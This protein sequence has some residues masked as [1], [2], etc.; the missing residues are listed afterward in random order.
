MSLRSPLRTSSQQVFQ[1][2]GPATGPQ[3]HLSCDSSVLLPGLQTKC[4]VL[5]CFLQVAHPLPPP[6]VLLGSWG[7]VSVASLLLGS[8]VTGCLP[9]L[10]N[11]GQQVWRQLSRQNDGTFAALLSDHSWLHAPQPPLWMHL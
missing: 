9:Q 11:S 4:W 7:Y 1:I 10:V 6:K 3:Q 8:G 5:L 2:P